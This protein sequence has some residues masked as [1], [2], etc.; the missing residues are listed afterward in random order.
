MTDGIPEKL[1]LCLGLPVMIR[2]NNATEIYMTCGQEDHVVGWDEGTGNHGQRVI[3]TLYVKLFKPA[4]TIN[5]P[6]LPENIV[7][8]TKQKQNIQFTLPNNE[9]FSLQ[10]CQVLVLPNF[11]MTGH[12]SQGKTRLDNIIN[13]LYC[14]NYMA[15]YTML[16][17]SSDAEGTI[18]L[19]RLIL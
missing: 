14:W 19:H 1:S 10:R 11:T 13:L 5:I 3:E 15:C 8:L 18:I 16:S 17:R 9:Q 2:N 7:P 12:A 4:K 6:G